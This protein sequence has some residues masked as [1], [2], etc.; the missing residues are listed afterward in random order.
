MP[1][2]ILAIAIVV[3]ILFLLMKSQADSSADKDL[4][5]L[6]R[7]DEAQMNRLIALEQKRKAGISRKEA[8]IRALESLRRDRG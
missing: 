7:D 5:T 3:L 8:V 4:L 1:Y 6:C 2:I